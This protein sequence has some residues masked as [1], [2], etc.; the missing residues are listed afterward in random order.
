MK[1]REAR[2]VAET[3]A[4]AQENGA[5]GI[6]HDRAVE[7][8]ICGAQR[9]NEDAPCEGPRNGKGLSVCGRHCGCENSRGRPCS[10]HGMP[11]MRCRNHGGLSLAG[12]ASPSWKS[13]ADSKYAAIF[14]GGA[15]EHYEEARKDPRYLEL[16]DN[17]AI[18]DTLK[19]EELLAARTGRGG[20]FV[21]ELGASWE[22]VR[23]VDPK[24]DP[25]GARA[26]LRDHGRLI[27]EG[28]SAESARK[29]ALDVMERQRR[30]SET[31]RKRIVDQE[32][33]ITQV[34]A[35]SFAA[36]YNA[37][38]RETLAGEPNERE[39]L[40]RFNAGAARLVGEYAGGGAGGPQAAQ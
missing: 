21:E 32:R 25:A 22:R 6:S 5:P 18:L 34:Q 12:P 16:R 9:K 3:D 35:M 26:A 27:E 15:W 24:K 40:A 13:G 39:L 17:M 29:R 37:L 33:T 8:G 19:M 38:M 36:A 4:P 20:A 23:S 11:N 7:L 1:G 28:V 30:T 14:T 31:E 2:A 10:K